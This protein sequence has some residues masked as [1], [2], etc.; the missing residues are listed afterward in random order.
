MAILLVAL[1][2]RTKTYFSCSSFKY[3]VTASCFNTGFVLWTFIRSL[4]EVRMFLFQS[5]SSIV[6]LGFVET[7]HSVLE[8]K[9]IC[10]FLL[11]LFQFIDI[12]SQKL[13]PLLTSFLSLEFVIISR[14]LVKTWSWFSSTNLYVVDNHILLC[15][16][17]MLY[18]YLCQWKI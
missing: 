17:R 4:R 6:T 18:C 7:I 9:P 11:H 13:R 3:S 15:L 2:I 14:S 8:S 10:I 12:A 5:F 1:S 16:Y